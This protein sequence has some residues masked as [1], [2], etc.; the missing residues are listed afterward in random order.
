MT[1]SYNYAAS[2]IKREPTLEEVELVERQGLIK[3]ALYNY[4][5]NLDKEMDKEKLKWIWDIYLKEL[6]KY[7]TFFDLY[8]GYCY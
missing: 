8:M 1:Y 7:N 3:N 4:Y 6:E 2:G 5:M